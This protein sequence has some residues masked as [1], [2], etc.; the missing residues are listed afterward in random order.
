MEYMEDE[1]DIEES[2]AALDRVKNWAYEQMGNRREPLDQQDRNRIPDGDDP[3]ELDD[4]TQNEG[5]EMPEDMELHRETPGLEIEIEQPMDQPPP[6][7]FGGGGKKELSVI[8][9]GHRQPKKPFP[10]DG[11]KDWSNDTVDKLDKFG[12][13][14]PVARRR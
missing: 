8:A 2:L 7:E 10:D 11:M 13:K 9:T 6:R 4:P 5:E 14:Q 3:A 1:R 12:R